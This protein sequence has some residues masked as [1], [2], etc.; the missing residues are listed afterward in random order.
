MSLCS[1]KEASRKK[2]MQIGTHIQ[3]DIWSILKPMEM[4]NTVK[5]YLKEW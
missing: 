5:Q 3:P 4:S 1:Q 2:G